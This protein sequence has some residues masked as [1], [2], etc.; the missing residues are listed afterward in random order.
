MNNLLST[1]DRLTSFLI[2]SYHVIFIYWANCN[3]ALK[4]LQTNLHMRLIFLAP[5]LIGIIKAYISPFDQLAS[6]S[7]GVNLL[8]SWDNLAVPK[9]PPCHF[10]KGS[11]DVTHAGHGNNVCSNMSKTVVEW[12][13]DWLLQYVKN[14]VQCN[15]WI[16]NEKL[17]KMMHKKV[18]FLT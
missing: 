7:H 11:C 10:A 17:L 18:Y 4:M 1:T 2:G 8:L 3:T 6:S 9:F 5:S 14:G 15:W 13:V 12:K 16:Q